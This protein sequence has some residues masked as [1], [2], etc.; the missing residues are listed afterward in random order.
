MAQ[1]HELTATELAGLIR[2]GEVS[3]REVVAAH[4]A[5]IEAV[6]GRVNAVT[7]V[8]SDSALAAADRADSVRQSGGALAPLCGVPFTVKESM[9]CLG[10][11][12]TYG[13]PALRESTPYLDAPVA[14]RMKA[15]GAIL[16]G[17]TNLS[18]MGLRLCDAVRVEPGLYRP[19]EYPA[20]PARLSPVLP[21]LPVEAVF[22]DL[23]LLSGDEDPAADDDSAETPKPTDP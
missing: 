2:A 17:R 5:R 13:V 8:L 9:D 18:E 21:P 19:A 23:P 22:L 14:A 7:V 11:A 4:L 1:L 6:N 10:T 12:T 16:I 3:S 20:E 15:A